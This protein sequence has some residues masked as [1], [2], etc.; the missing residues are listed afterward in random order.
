MSLSDALFNPVAAYIVQLTVSFQRHLQRVS[1][2][3]AGWKN[4]QFH[5]TGLSCGR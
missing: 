5:A 1:F 4:N 2:T 3:E